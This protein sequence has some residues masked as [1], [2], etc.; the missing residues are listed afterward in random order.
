MDGLLLSEATCCYAGLVVCDPRRWS[1]RLS[2]CVVLPRA[3]RRV[4]FH[5]QVRVFPDPRAMFKTEN[6]QHTFAEP[7]SNELLTAQAD[8]VGDALAAIMEVH[9]H[10]HPRILMIYVRC[11][12][13]RL[14]T[15]V[16]GAIG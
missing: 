13:N 9:R 3:W 4:C 10:M 14:A 1:N 15:A 6:W 7:V 8:L 16:M 12:V 5:D 11:G 2:L